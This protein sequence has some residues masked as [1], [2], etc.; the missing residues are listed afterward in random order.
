MAGIFYDPRVHDIWGSFGQGI[1]QGFN[2][3]L[4]AIQMKKNL[5]MAELEKEKLGLANKLYKAA[6]TEKENEQKAEAE[7]AGLRKKYET[8]VGDL[9]KNAPQKMVAPKAPEQPAALPDLS[10]D[11]DVERN[12]VMASE[13]YKTGLANVAKY[14]SDQEEHVKKQKAFDENEAK[15]KEHNLKLVNLLAEQ[16]KDIYSTYLKHGQVEK[17]VGVRKLQYEQMKA[18]ASFSPTAALEYAKNGIDGKLFEGAKIKDQKEFSVIGLRDGSAIRWNK[19]TGA[20]DIVKGPDDSIATKIEDIYTGGGRQKAIFQTNKKGGV[21]VTPVGGVAPLFK[22]D[23]DDEGKKIKVGERNIARDL[24][25][26]AFMQ[27]FGTTVDE[28]TGE[29]KFMT[30]NQLQTKLKGIPTAENTN[31]THADAYNFMRKRAADYLE[32]G[33]NP[34]AAADQA[35]VDWTREA[36]GF[37]GGRAQTPGTG[38]KP[39][40]GIPG[41]AKQGADGAWYVPD[42]RSKTGW[43]KVSPKQ[44]PTKPIPK[45]QVPTQPK[46]TPS[47]LPTRPSG[48]S[49]RAWD[50]MTSEQQ[51]EWREKRKRQYFG[52]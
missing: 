31:Y 46:Q 36:P 37:V 22:P 8:T 2:T 44:A 23:S 11:S 12:A 49:P 43:G 5:E 33:M 18:L 52:E 27:E 48:I 50:S 6:V 1:T 10:G 26:R 3:G 17:A 24:I 21:T 28:A 42:S 30:V 45:A 9:A 47:A 41:N 39:P 14:K 15:V 16:D 13:G 7:I 32:K 4:A 19:E 29:T 40:A 38:A 25:D 51:Q 20:V 34:E 35:K